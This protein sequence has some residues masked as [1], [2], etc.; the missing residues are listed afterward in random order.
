MR[1][2][3]SPAAEKEREGVVAGKRA[4]QLHAYLLQE[5]GAVGGVAGV[6]AGDLHGDAAV[7]LE[8]GLEPRAGV[9]VHD[10][11]PLHP[12]R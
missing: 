8:E 12:I 2:A 1:A 4:P 3:A 5:V 10:R 11:D 6:A 9:S 7:R